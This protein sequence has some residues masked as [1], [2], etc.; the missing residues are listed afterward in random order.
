MNA[1]IRTP[2]AS[3]FRAEVIFWRCP[4]MV[5]QLVLDHFVRDLSHCR[6]EVAPCPEMLPPVPLLQHRIL[7]EQLA[8]TSS[9]HPPHDLAGASVGGALTRICTWSA[10]TTPLEDAKL[11]RLT[12]LPDQL[13]HAHRYIPLRHLVSVFRH[14]YEC[15]VDRNWQLAGMNERHA[16]ILLSNPRCLMRRPCFLVIGSPWDWSLATSPQ[17]KP[18]PFGADFEPVR[19]I[20]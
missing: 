4:E 11:E 13:P 8:R 9:F 14:P 20:A 3:I 18:F 10:L 5:F 2:S 7:P 15:V 17:R 19:T 16:G 1:G 6:A 12:R